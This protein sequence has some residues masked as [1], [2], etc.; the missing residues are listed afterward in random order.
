MLVKKVQRRECWADLENLYLESE[1]LEQDLEENYT[2][3]VH[4]FESF[5]KLEIRRGEARRDA[6]R[7]RRIRRE[8]NKWAV[9]TTKS[10]V[11]RRKRADLNEAEHLAQHELTLEEM[12]TLSFEKVRIKGQ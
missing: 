4:A 6:D 10:K 8:R 5:R 1:D 2:F 11:L 12:T 7:A 3:E 9:K